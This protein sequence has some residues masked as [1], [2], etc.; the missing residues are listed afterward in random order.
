MTW[1]AWMR[2]F[3]QDSAIHADDYCG[4]FYS[5][6]KFT[7]EMAEF[8]PFYL[9]VKRVPEKATE[10]KLKQ[11]KHRKSRRLFKLGTSKS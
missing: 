6:P 10:R 8:I 11:Q 3:F 2:T 1:E 9:K 7:A 4:W 5:K